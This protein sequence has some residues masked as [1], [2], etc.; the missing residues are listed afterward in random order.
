M[1]FIGRTLEDVGK[2]LTWFEKYET[3]SKANKA[4]IHQWQISKRR[5]RETMFQM[6]NQSEKAKIESSKSH[7]EM[8]RAKREEEK[9]REHTRLVNWKV[10]TKK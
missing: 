3:L 10:N 9:D 5:E 7:Q 1:I 6:A 8:V 4:Y 2:H